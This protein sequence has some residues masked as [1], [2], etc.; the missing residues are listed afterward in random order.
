MMQSASQAS[1]EECAFVFPMP[2][3]RRLLAGMR[4]PRQTVRFD[5]LI[6]RHGL[7]PYRV[8]Q[9]PEQP[10]PDDT[11]DIA[12]D[13]VRVPVGVDDDATFGLPFGDRSKSLAKPIVKPLSS[14]SKRSAS[15]PSRRC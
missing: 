2:E 7:R 8:R 11:P 10:L 9:G 14:A 5:A 13:R 1:V 15:S 4:G 6:S 3:E 12:F